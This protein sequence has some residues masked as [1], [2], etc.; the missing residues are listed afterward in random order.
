MSRITNVDNLSALID[1]LICERIKLFFFEKDNKVP[2]IV[3]QREIISQL[4]IRISDAFTQCLVE[5]KY[6]YIE[7]RRTFN[8]N[9]VIGELEKLTM[10]N[11]EIGQGDRTALSG[12]K[13]SSADKMKL[14]IF[15][16][17]FHN[18]SRAQS[19]TKMDSI[20]KKIFKK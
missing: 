10:H 16:F 9:D 1:R 8:I 5:K 11:I 14:G 20:F 15:S 12:A 6:D 4:K 3:H 17:R 7:E 18:E 2:E 19:K 13:E